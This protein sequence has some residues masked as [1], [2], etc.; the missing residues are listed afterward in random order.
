MND[1]E[2]ELKKQPLR[3]VPEHWRGQILAAAKTPDTLKREH[4]PWWAALLWPSP[5][6]WGGLAAAW[7]VMVCFSAVTREP[8]ASSEAPKAAQMRM[9]LEQKRLLQAEME[10]AAVHFDRESPKPRSELRDAGRPA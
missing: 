4:Q 9:A 3:R 10:E 1:F 8:S 6:A 2:N 5:K 7:L